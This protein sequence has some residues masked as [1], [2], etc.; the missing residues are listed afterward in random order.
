MNNRGP[1]YRFSVEQL[2]DHMAG[3]GIEKAIV[4]HALA[5][6]SHPSLGNELLLREISGH[7]NLH[8][9]FVLLPPATDELGPLERYIDAMISNHVY[10]VK[11]FPESQRFSVSDWSAG[12]LL[13]IL[14]ERRVPLFV[15]SKEISWDRVQ[16]I[17]KKYPTLPV[18]IEQSDEETYRNLRYLY[19]LMDSC[20]NL[21]VQI[22]NSHLYLQVDEV[23]DRFG[24]ERLLFST[25]YPVDDPHVALMIVTHGEFS[26]GQ[27]EMIAHGNL[28]RL[29]NGV[30]K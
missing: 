10:T 2:Q 22:H 28:E 5:R 6:Y 1:E 13:E 30:V 24:A 3:C 26:Q 14:A 16:S 7:D 4:T 21:Y 12:P 9:S 27:K 8:G 11:I 15:W 18:V 23:V 25:Y 20:E 19:P 29:L 17:C